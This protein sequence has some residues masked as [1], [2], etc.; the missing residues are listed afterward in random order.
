M[1]AVVAAVFVEGNQTS[2]AL[3]DSAATL[4]ASIVRQAA[5]HMDAPQIVLD[6]PS[7]GELSAAFGS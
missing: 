4:V 3:E 2:T 1:P 5:R 7:P 6:P